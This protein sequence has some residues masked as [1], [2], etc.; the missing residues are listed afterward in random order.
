MNQ[1]KVEKVMNPLRRK[2]VLATW[3]APSEGNI[4]G[5]L[6]LD[7]GRASS[8]IAYLR[9]KTGK[10][11]T[12]TH[13]IGRAIAEAIKN[14]P[15]VNGFIRMGRFVPHDGVAISFLIAL[16][17]GANL[18]NTKIE[19]A[20]SLTLEQI[21]DHLKDAADRSRSGKDKDF[22]KSQGMLKILPSWLIRP[23]LW[24]TGWITSSLGFSAPA[25]GLS[26]FPFGTC[27][28]TSVGM[29]GLDEA[30]APHTPFARLPILAL[31]GAIKKQAVVIDD[32][33]TIRPILTLTATIDHRYIDGSQ[34][35]NLA[36]TIR[37]AFQN[38]WILDGLN[39]PPEDWS[40]E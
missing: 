7:T 14:T 28:I 26:A 17:N 37:E 33:I 18:A 5:K 15:A 39:S 8:Y 10:K 23:I 36:N 3:S 4:Y 2:L 38:P 31:I 35:A 6:N 32:T 22:E 20:H 29:L 24:L 34:A 19:N 21:A 11:I 40:Q 30:F 12:I 27:M 1:R 16:E 25:F 13:F 9:E